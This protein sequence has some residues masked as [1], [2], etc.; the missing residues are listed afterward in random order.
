MHSPPFFKYTHVPKVGVKL[1]L[2]NILSTDYVSRLLDTFPIVTVGLYIAVMV[3]GKIPDPRVHR[4]GGEV[5]WFGAD[6]AHIFLY[7]ASLTII[8]GI[9]LLIRRYGRIRSIFESG[10]E[11]AGTVTVTDGS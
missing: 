1:S 3:F 9:P 7:V 5:M 11:T 8:L 10:V 4:Y 6:Q 2:R